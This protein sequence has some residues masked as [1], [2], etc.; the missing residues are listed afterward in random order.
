MAEQQWRTI[1]VGGKGVHA[2]LL[3]PRVYK[4]NKAGERLYTKQGEPMSEYATPSQ[5]CSQP[6]VDWATRQEDLTPTEKGVKDLFNEVKVLLRQSKYAAVFYHAATDP[7]SLCPH[8]HY[9]LLFSRD[10][11]RDFDKD[12][13]W[14]SIRKAAKAASER[15]PNNAYCISQRVKNLEAI[16]RYLSRA[17][18]VFYGTSSKAIFTWRNNEVKAPP[19]TSPYSDSWVDDEP[20]IDGLLGKDLDATV[21]DGWPQIDLGVEGDFVE[22][23]RKRMATDW[24]DDAAAGTL[25][26][27]PATKKSSYTGKE[28]ITPRLI[29]ICSM[30]MRKFGTT[31]RG[32]LRGQVEMHIQ[33]GTP[34]SHNWLARLRNINYSRNA[35]QI[36]Q[37]A[38]E[39]YK[40][41]IQRAPV[42]E[43]M[44]RCW[45][46][47]GSSVGRTRPLIPLDTSLS[48]WSDWIIHNGWALHE[49][50]DNFCRLLSN[51][52]DKRN[53][54]FIFG[55]SNAGKSVMFA[56]PIEAIMI[57]VGRV[58]QMNTSSTFI[59]ESCIGR[60]LIS[61]EECTV[62]PNHVEECKKLM[63][64]EICQVNVK[65]VREGGI[66]APTPV[67]ATANMHPWLFVPEH[68][69]AIVNR[70]YLYECQH[71][72]KH[73]EPW[74]GH[75]LDPRVYILLFYLW[76]QGVVDYSDLFDDDKVKY[77]CDQIDEEAINQAA[78]EDLLERPSTYSYYDKSEPAPPATGQSL[79]GHI[80]GVP[81]HSPFQLT[82]RQLK[83]IDPQFHH[84]HFTWERARPVADFFV[85]WVRYKTMWLG[86]A[87]GTG[88]KMPSMPPNHQYCAA[89]GMFHY[90]DQ[91]QRPVGRSDDLWLHRI[92]CGAATLHQQPASQLERRTT[93]GEPWRDSFDRCNPFG[94]AMWDDT[95]DAATDAGFVETGDCPSSSSTTTTTTTSSRDTTASG[96]SMGAV[97]T[98][99]SVCAQRVTYVAPYWRDRTLKDIEI[100][101]V[102]SFD[103]E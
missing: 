52:G 92:V 34:Q 61:I 59:F 8:N 35:N 31:D 53:C 98:G 78:T 12:Y 24:D 81:V 94:A 38:G 36:Y 70:C 58:I 56:H 72:F 76:R 20:T 2:R 11:T 55:A 64:G 73:L 45:M 22:N 37:C 103:S 96:D 101:N 67:I 1:V 15:L 99:Q 21:A 84:S 13:R 27:P 89:C 63:G 54:M 93:T 17:P 97:G 102:Y 32:L 44:L 90:S 100:M 28:A 3:M 86:V 16:T 30:L 18:R 39:E 51:R 26:G 46:Q 5:V 29:F 47:T 83:A 7:C 79:E 48:I 95:R 80:D 9:H 88:D 75:A 91:R 87:T 42:W 14:R 85:C 43:L 19:S 50:V 33:A 60:R 10:D 49:F 25:G 6:V 40:H 4:A 65:N 77:Y 71:S 62:P 23:A 82:V 57:N 41:Y 74:T 68:R 69:E 66:V